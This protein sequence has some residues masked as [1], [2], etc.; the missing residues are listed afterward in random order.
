MNSEEQAIEIISYFVIQYRKAFNHGGDY[1]SIE[2]TRQTY[3]E[4]IKE[5]WK[6]SEDDLHIIYLKGKILADQ[7]QLDRHTKELMRLED[8]QYHELDDVKATTD[9]I[10]DL[11]INPSKEKIEKACKG[12]NL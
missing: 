11:G 9:R 2:K 3:C 5:S 8:K 7:K 4:S 12:V 10:F 6:L 1:E